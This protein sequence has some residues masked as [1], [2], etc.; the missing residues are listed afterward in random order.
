MEQLKR[1]LYVELV[2]LQN[3]TDREIEIMFLLSLEDAIRRPLALASGQE[4]VPVDGSVIN[5]DFGGQK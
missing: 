1:Q 3:P 5:F 2:K 4:F